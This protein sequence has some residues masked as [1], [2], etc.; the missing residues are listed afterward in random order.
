MT[1]QRIA[2]NPQRLHSE[3]LTIEPS[4]QLSALLYVK[5]GKPGLF[6]LF[7]ACACPQFFP[8]MCFMIRIFH[9]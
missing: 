8:L 6:F 7:P 3:P 4:D 2:M 1:V 9:S 5:A